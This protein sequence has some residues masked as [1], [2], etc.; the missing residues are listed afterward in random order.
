MDIHG[1]F[2]VSK[3]QMIEKIP[4]EECSA[5]PVDAQPASANTDSNMENGAD[6]ASAEVS[7]PLSNL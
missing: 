4:E 6:D 5:E 3:A 2:Y 1:I 7:R